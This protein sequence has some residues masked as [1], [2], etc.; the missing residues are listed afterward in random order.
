MK[1]ALYLY[2][3]IKIHNFYTHSLAS[4][5]L[6]SLSLLGALVVATLNIK[7]R[8]T[9]AK[10][11]VTVQVLEIVQGNLRGQVK[12]IDAAPNGAV[13]R[14]LEG[15]DFVSIRRAEQTTIHVV[16]QAVAKD[17]SNGGDQVLDALDDSAA[18]V[19]LGLVLQV[20]F[21]AIHNVGELRL[22][23][24]ERSPERRNGQHLVQ[25]R[26]WDG[27][28][29]DAHN[30][31]LKAGGFVIKVLDVVQQG[32][33]G[34]AELGVQDLDELIKADA[35]R[36]HV[37][38]AGA[39]SGI[40]VA[41]RVLQSPYIVCVVSHLHKADSHVSVLEGCV[42]HAVGAFEAFTK[43]ARLPFDFTR[44]QKQVDATCHSALNLL[45][46]G[47]SAGA[48]DKILHFG[49]GTDADGHKSS[50]AESAQALP[51]S[52]RG[53]FF[54]SWGRNERARSV[55]VRGRE[56]QL[57]SKVHHVEV[58]TVSCGSLR[59]RRAVHNAFVAHLLVG[60]WSASVE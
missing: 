42:H 26:G 49:Q 52:S 33:A 22:K 15:L 41:V 59:R 46:A 16:G 6:N 51:D 28:A 14:R 40:V 47:A 27:S 34:R 56:V 54:W 19:A 18:K 7:H 32:L 13:A 48:Q 50:R 60:C 17:A 12:H 1:D 23:N 10:P 43:R 57:D 35:A 39:E 37:H 25:G 55:R 11:Q 2:K 38:A 53:N 9:V 44:R 31:E 4:P 21:S 5:F 20:V 24:T 58:V 29:C 45:H 3:E 8:S 36:K 30:A